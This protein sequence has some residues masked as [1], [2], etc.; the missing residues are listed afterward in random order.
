M[1]DQY[2]LLTG[3]KNNA[4]DFLIKHRAKQLLAALRPDR[5][6]IEYDAWKPLT[7]EQLD[8]GI[9]NL[10][11]AS[12][13]DNRG[14]QAPTPDQQ[15]AFEVIDALKDV[16]SRQFPTYPAE[17][18][19]IQNDLQNTLADVGINKY[20][21][22]KPR[23]TQR[24]IEPAVVSYRGGDA[25]GR[26]DAMRAIMPGGPRRES[27]E[28]VPGMRAAESLRGRGKLD[29]RIVAGPYGARAYSPDLGDV[30]RLRAAGLQN[31]GTG[32]AR[33]PAVTHN[34]KKRRKLNDLSRREELR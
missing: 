2:V 22:L 31:V 24:A 8:V 29:P 7:A 17:P 32:M 9:R 21:K 14:G 23:E 5:A 18:A 13:Y 26:D 27:L 10:R 1:M 19:G 33:V 30:A 12:G 3:G 28:A 4:G 34:R 25:V 11:R 20:G 6:L 16:R 15:I